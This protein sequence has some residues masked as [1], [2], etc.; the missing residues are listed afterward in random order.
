LE[1]RL[2][3][4]ESGSG[5]S[6]YTPAIP[7]NFN[8]FTPFYPT[9]FSNDS[10]Y[11]Y[12]RLEPWKLVIGVLVTTNNNEYNEVLFQINKTS[13]SIRIGNY[14]YD[15]TTEELKLETI[16]LLSGKVINN[17]TRLQLVNGKDNTSTRLLNNVN[18]VSFMGDY[19]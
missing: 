10:F 15:K 13:N 3:V 4:L 7:E 11:N 8:K 16:R 14:F 6:S 1:S 9:S 19:K 17:F 2:T 5:G 18:D 12:F